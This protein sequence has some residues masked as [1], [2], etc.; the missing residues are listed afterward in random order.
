MVAAFSP[1]ADAYDAYVNEVELGRKLRAELDRRILSGRPYSRHLDEL[2]VLTIEPLSVRLAAMVAH[3]P[4]DQ[5][6]E[7]AT[8]RQ[9]IEEQLE[10]RKR[11]PVERLTAAHP[12]I[13]GQIQSLKSW[14]FSLDAA[15]LRKAAVLE[16]R[17]SADVKLLGLKA[18]DL[19]DES[20]RKLDEWLAD[21]K[22]DATRKLLLAFTRARV[23]HD[24]ERMDPIWMAELMEGKWITPKGQ[25]AS[26]MPLDWRHPGAHSLYWSSMGVR[27][28]KGVSKVDEIEV[29]NT[30]RHTLHSLQLLAYN[31]KILFAP[32]SG[33]YRQLPNPEFIVPYET[34]MFGSKDRLS[35]R[36]RQ[37][38]T[39][40]GTFDD[41]HE[42]FLIWAVQ[43]AYFYGSQQQASALYQR[44]RELYIQRGESRSIRYIRPLEDFVVGQMIDNDSITNP[45]DIKAFVT[46]LIYQAIEMGLTSGQP[47]IAS[48]YLM[49]ARTYHAA[50]QAKQDPAV[51][52]APEG[53]TLLPPFEQLVADVFVRYLT[54]PIES[55]QGVLLKARAWA[56]APN[57]LRLQVY[58]MTAATLNKQAASAGLNGSAAFPPPQGLEQYRAEQ[59]KDGKKPA[60]GIVPTVPELR[61]KDV[62]K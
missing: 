37:E 59:D 14:G 24:Q 41:A 26:P 35:T 10:Q 40:P 31:G 9:L 38:T 20:D 23:I 55:G 29:L 62:V 17:R 34:G 6:R 22:L 11:D 46:G 39:A 12:Q 60:G 48:R 8:L 1:I 7:L 58:E 28:S 45:D 21:P 44:L 49:I 3:L 43:M 19:T 4:E 52:I 54:Q 53:R 51:R 42:N 36:Q 25:T 27:R 5:A 50:N 33:Y 56:A 30:D 2:R 57:A 13:A 32:G 47:E 16:T 15:L 18:M 61:S